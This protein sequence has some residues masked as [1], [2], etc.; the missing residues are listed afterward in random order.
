MASDARE[1]ETTFGPQMW[2]VLVKYQDSSGN[3][4]HWKKCG[5]QEEFK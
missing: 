2:V 3:H 1:S 5:A 4:L